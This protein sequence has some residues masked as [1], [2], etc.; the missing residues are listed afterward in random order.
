MKNVLVKKDKTVEKVLEKVENTLKEACP[1]YLVILSIRTI[2]SG[3]LNVL[4]AITVSTMIV[5]F[6]SFKHKTWFYWNRDKLKGVMIK[7]DLFLYDMLQ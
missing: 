5:P 3:K 2:V 7:L 4:K 1:A 6:T